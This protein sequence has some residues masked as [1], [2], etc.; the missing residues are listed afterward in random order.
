MQTIYL[1]ISNKGV[2]PCV[3][4]KQSEVGR[5]FL[6]VIT[7]NGVPYNIPDNSLL[8]VWYE[9]DTDAGNYSSIEEKSAFSIDGNKVVVELVAQMLLKPGKGDLCLS[10]THGNGGET[11]TWNIPYEVEYKPGAGSSV[12]TEYYT[13]LT[14]AGAYAAEQ[15][16]IAKRYADQAVSATENKLDLTGGTMDGDI[17]MGGHKVTGLGKPVVSEDAVPLGYALGAFA[18]AGYGLGKQ[19][20]V[21][22]TSLS[23]LDNTYLN[24][25]YK[26]QTFDEENIE[27][28]KLGLLYVN[29]STSS[30]EQI[31]VPY[32]NPYR[33]IRVNHAEDG[34]GV[35]EYENPP[36]VLGVE[37]RT[38]ER[39]QNKP[40]Y[41]MLVDCG[42][43]PN[44]N[45][46][47]IAFN[48]NAT[49]ALRCVGQAS[50]GGS[51]PSLYD[52]NQI[53]AFAYTGYIYITTNYDAGG[54][55]AT[56][57][58]WYIKD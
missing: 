31:F 3:Q 33:L 32:R 30:V 14:E 34:W 4:A 44:Y 13:A 49:R 36:M 53:S 57:Q 10:V 45:Q 41:T 28:H 55:T 5:K 58:V 56:A 39:W 7:D 22:I 1:D 50:D 9:G 21:T 47:Q 51:I 38:T 6:A 43:M 42:I 24:G 54:G 18:P 46:K 27:G 35:W 40:V 11:N 15:A 19:N 37:Y 17:A 12:P 26:F 25:W 23:A 52:G 20:E 2:I 29:S 48:P 8:S 16:A